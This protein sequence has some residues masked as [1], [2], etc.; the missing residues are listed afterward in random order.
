MPTYFYRP[1]GKVMFSQVFVCS[2]SASWLLVHCS[3]LVGTHPTRMLSCLQ[4]VRRKLYETKEIGPGGVARV[5]SVSLESAND[6]CFC[7]A[8][9]KL[10]VRISEN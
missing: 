7:N 8:I 3:S 6:Q 4:N 10:M 2:Q 9:C 1:E 5:P